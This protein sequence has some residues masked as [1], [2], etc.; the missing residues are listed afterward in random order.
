MQEATISAIGAGTLVNVG[1]QLVMN[2]QQGAGGVLLT[3]SAVFG[4]LIWRALRRV[5]RIDKFEKG[6]RG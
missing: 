5:K 4:F 1:S 6:M 2:G 3:G